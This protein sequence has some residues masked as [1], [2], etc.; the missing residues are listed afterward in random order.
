MVIG[1]KIGVTSRWRLNYGDTIAISV[2][3]GS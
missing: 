3:Y 2:K 1:E